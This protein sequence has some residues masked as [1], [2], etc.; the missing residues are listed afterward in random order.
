MHPLNLNHISFNQATNSGTRK[1]SLA[2]Y[3]LV[4]GADNRHGLAMD[5]PLRLIS[6][7]ADSEPGRHPSA[8]NYSVFITEHNLFECGDCPVVEYLGIPI[9]DITP[10]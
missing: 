7:D 8:S 10:F 9:R 6:M 4:R 3:R 2:R 1:V 5:E